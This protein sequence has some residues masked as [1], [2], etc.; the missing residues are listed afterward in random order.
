M[1]SKIKIAFFLIAIAAVGGAALLWYRIPILN[2]TAPLVTVSEPYQTPYV[3]V[4][5]RMYRT[6]LFRFDVQYPEDVFIREWSEG[7]TTTITFEDATAEKGFQ[8]F[9]VPYE[10]ETVDAQRFKMDI[11]T[12]IMREEHEIM[13]DGTRALAFFSEN[14]VLGETR[15]VWFLKNGFLYEIT[16]QKGLDNWL[17]E[18]LST[19]KF[20]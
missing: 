15:E 10:G 12:G 2:A 14:L 8:I 4:G 3:R 9:I 5:W 1:G 13:L 11:P 6:N 19:W 7:N 16:A 18:I 17:A 20:L